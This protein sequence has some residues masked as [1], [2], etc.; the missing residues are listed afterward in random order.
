[1][2]DVDNESKKVVITKLEVWHEKNYEQ[3]KFNIDFFDDPGNWYF[4]ITEEI[5]CLF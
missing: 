4:Q 2:S 3:N 1:M 5:F